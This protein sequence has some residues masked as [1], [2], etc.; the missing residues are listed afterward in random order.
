MPIFDV[1]SNLIMIAYTGIFV[2]HITIGVFRC[3][4]AESQIYALSQK[5]FDGIKFFH[6]GLIFGRIF[7]PK[8]TCLY[9]AAFY[10]VN[11]YD[12]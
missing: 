8:W 4:Q 12:R 5:N 1:H 11:V 3:E 9:I 2:I 7:L 6:P 10:S